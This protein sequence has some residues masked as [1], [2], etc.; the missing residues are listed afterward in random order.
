MV[1][2]VFHQSGIITLGTPKTPVRLSFLHVDEPKKFNDAADAKAKYQG[3]ALIDPTT[4]EGAE[5]IKR[6]KGEII[7]LAKKAYG[8]QLPAEIRSGQ[9]LCLQ[10]NTLPDGTPRKEYD[11]YKGMYYFVASN[12]AAPIVYNRKAEIITPSEEQYPES[13]DYGIVKAKLWAQDNEYGKRINA[14]LLTVQFVRAGEKFGKGGKVEIPDGEVQAL[15][16]EPAA[17]GGVTSTDD[18]AF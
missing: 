5:L 4:V 14:N 6:L 2:K 7:A 17:A 9:N 18:I 1:K 10:N 3:T 8:D 15:G 13:G 16:D 11:G 12:D